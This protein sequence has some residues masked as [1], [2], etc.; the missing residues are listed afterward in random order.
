MFHEGCSYHLILYIHIYLYIHRT[1]C[2]CVHEICYINAFLNFSSC[3]TNVSYS[4][5]KPDAIE[6][7]LTGS[8]NDK[9]LQS[10]SWRY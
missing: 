3:H 2:L 4:K 7:V 8:C 1:V 6:V 9:E 10:C 5:P